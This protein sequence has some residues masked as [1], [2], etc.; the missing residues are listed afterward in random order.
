MCN[1]INNENEFE[2]EGETYVAVDDWNFTYCGCFKR[3][4]R[5]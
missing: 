2:Y 4:Y 1:N 3:Q 5:L